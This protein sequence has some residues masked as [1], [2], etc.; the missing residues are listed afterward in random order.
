MMEKLKMQIE[1]KVDK[2]IDA[3]GKMFPN[4]LTEAIKGYDEN[5]KAIIEQVIDFDLLKQ[6]LSNVV[7]E[8]NE[9]RYQMNWPDKK[10]S[11]LLA[12]A[13][14][15]KTLRPCKEESVDFDGTE[16]LYIEGD[17]LD[18]LKLL[19]ETY[20]NR[21][22][23]IYIDPPYNTG[24]DSFVYNDDFDMDS[25]EFSDASG[26]YDE[27]GNMLFDVRQNNESNG[28]FHT[29]WLNMMYPRLKLAKDL[30]TEDGVIFIS[31]DDNEV[32][33]L[34]K[35][36]NEIFGEHKFVGC[37]ANVNNPKGRSDD[38]YFATA[39]EYIY[40]FQK[41]QA[42]LYG[43]EPEETVLR[44]YNK[45]DENGIKYR[46]IDL[47]KTGDNDRKVDRPNLYYYFYYNNLN[48]D[49]LAS[50]E[51]KTI[52]GHVK[53]YPTRKDG[54]L[55]NWRWQIDTAM[56]NKHLLIP[57]YSDTGDKWMIYVKDILSENL[58]IKPTTVWTFKDV[59]SERGTEQFIDLG[60]EKT[61]FAKPK[62]IGTIERLLK[63]STES[64]DIILDF[65]SGSSTTAH[66]VMHLNAE[67]GGNRKFIMV[68]LPEETE[69]NSE[70]N[71]AGY[72]NICEIGKKRIVKAGEKIKKEN[73]D[74]AESL[75]TGFRV[76][77]LDSTNMKEVFYKPA[78]LLQ[79]ALDG[80]EENI[81]DDRSTEDLLFQ[82]MLELGELLSSDINEIIIAGKKVFNVGGGNIIACFDTK[83]T[84]EVVTEIAKL[85]PMYA[86]FRD[87]CMASDS[88]AT[89]FEEIFK[90]YSPNTT[91][92]IL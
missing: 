29:D 37:I 11:I 9:E 15:D 30:L 5:G 32:E 59:N 91:R 46:E 24:K 89:N 20:L 80:F 68:Q 72:K 53:I 25:Y 12:N 74:K 27:D 55:G 63:I 22:K 85:K 60:F 67:D 41:G 78:Q 77:K 49:L 19:R 87:N 35:V 88:V 10:K 75:D 42:R 56:A 81:K 47:R 21:V 57:K 58:R 26:Q 50:H 76:L 86:V 62:P 17:N 36:C 92:K 40:V 71:K 38:K 54:T 6:E 14:I 65:F 16:N 2:N 45:V 43:F 4:T 13:P 83:I 82:V 51:D 7:V 23:M 33:N 61:I 3:I 18:V 44:R 69:E 28:R 52:D 84:N 39:H 1:S 70:A 66:A 48:N 79:S 64:N 31:I 90:T 34:K 8:G 73:P